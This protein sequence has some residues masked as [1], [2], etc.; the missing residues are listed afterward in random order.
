[1]RKQSTPHQA[2][3][4]LHHGLA[5]MSSHSPL[6]PGGKALQ[7]RGAWESK[8]GRA[9]SSVLCCASDESSGDIEWRDFEEARALA[10]R[11]GLESRKDWV[12]LCMN[13]ERPQDIP[14]DPALIYGGE[15]GLWKGWPDFLG[16]EVRG[17]GSRWWG[18]R[19]F[20]EARGFVWTLGLKSQK[21]WHEWS[22]SRERPVDMPSNPDIVYDEEGW[23]SWPDFLGYEAVVWR[24][25]EE[26]RVY[27]RGL[28]FKSRMDWRAWSKSG[29]RPDDIPARPDHVYK[30]K[31][32]KSYG[33]F[34]GYNEGN[35]PGE[36]RSFEEARDYASSLK[37]KSQREWKEWSKSGERPQDIPSHPE[38]VYKHAGWKSWPDFL[39]YPPRRNAKT[40]ST[41][42]KRSFTEARDYARNLSLE[43]VREWEGWSKSGKRPPDIPSHPELVYKGKGWKSWGDFLGYDEG[44]VA[45]DWRS[46]EEAR[47]YASRLKLKSQ[48]EWKEWSESGKRPQDI[49]S[50]PNI[51]YKGKGWK[52]WGDF[53]GYQFQ[54]RGRSRPQKRRSDHN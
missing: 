35:A 45:G 42:K 6:P 50:N 24:S 8:A 39:G 31:G 29:E 40:R 46:F 43:S 4:Y 51:V 14:V 53:L 20:E 47:D 32:W 30:G 37:L 9:S 13:R 22:K 2:H 21:E 41:T 16:Y 23:L 33:D 5:H 18:W 28:G 26:A 36:W 3:S 11:L 7:M 27:A 12:E 38:R 17:R 15:G 25:F 48:R 44:Y 10:R 34:L 52:S 1:M 54:N 19:S 49:P